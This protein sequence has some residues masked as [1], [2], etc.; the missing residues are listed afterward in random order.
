MF[1]GGPLVNTPIFGIRT[2]RT[3]TA[4]FFR[5]EPRHGYLFSGLLTG[6]SRLTKR[7]FKKGHAHALLVLSK[8]CGNAGLCKAM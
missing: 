2:F 5:R 1:L 6:E 3:P 7:T 4:S 8:E